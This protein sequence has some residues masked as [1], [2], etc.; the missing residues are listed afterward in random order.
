MHVASMIRMCIYLGGQ[1]CRL[2]QR[3]LAFPGQPFSSS[4]IGM[5][6]DPLLPKE[7]MYFLSSFATRRVF[8]QA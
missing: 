7:R 4:S 3:S 8:D 6:S 1:R 2:W 5:E